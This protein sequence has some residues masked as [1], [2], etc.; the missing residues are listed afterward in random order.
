M[1][2]RLWVVLVNLFC[3][4]LLV[5]KVVVL[6]VCLKIILMSISVDLYLISGY[7]FY[8]SGLGF[9]LDVWLEIWF[10]L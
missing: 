2:K 6:K 7:L 3:F 10:C 5:R 1:V 9:L 4:N 8:L